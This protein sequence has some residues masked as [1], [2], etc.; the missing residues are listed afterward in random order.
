MSYP[1]ANGCELTGWGMPLSSLSV[2]IKNTTSGGN[3]ATSPVQC[4]ELI[5]IKASPREVRYTYRSLKSIL[6]EEA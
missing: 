5:L 1:L 2:H 6:K 4:I 3:R